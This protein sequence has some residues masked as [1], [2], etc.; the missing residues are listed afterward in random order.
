MI[1]EKRKYPTRARQSAGRNGAPG[2]DGTKWGPRKAEGLCGE[3][4]SNEMKW[5][6][7]ARRAERS[8]VCEDD[9]GDEA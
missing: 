8:G 9:G 6:L 7:A 4:T 3:R 1:S 2:K 5:M